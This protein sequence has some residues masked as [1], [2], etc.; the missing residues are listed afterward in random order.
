[1]ARVLK[2]ASQP[3]QP[4]KATIQ[5]LKGGKT[6]LGKSS[7]RIKN[8][9]STKSTTQ[10]THEFSCREDGNQKTSIIEIVR[11]SSHL[12]KKQKHTWK[13]VQAQM[14]KA[15]RIA[16]QPGQLAKKH[17]HILKKA[18]VKIARASKMASQPLKA[19]L[20]FVNLNVENIVQKNKL[21]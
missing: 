18:L 11:I 8:V 2:I 6:S 5:I 9:K 17:I 4:P 20:P 14:V 12:V 13:L 16:S 7:K 10:S 1:M 15:S 19:H 3:N 21:T